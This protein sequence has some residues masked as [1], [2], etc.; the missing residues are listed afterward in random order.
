MK[1]VNKLALVGLVALLGG[2]LSG[3]QKDEPEVKTNPVQEIIN[4]AEKMDEE[5]LYKKAVEEINGKSF[6]VIAN[7]SRMKDAFPAWVKFINEN[8]K[9]KFGL[10][11]DFKADFSTTQPKNNT[12]FNQIK[13]DVTGTNH[14]ISMTLIQDGSQIK[15]KMTKPGYLLNYIPKEWKESGADVAKDGTPLALQSLSKVFAYNSIDTEEGAFNNVFDFTM[16]DDGTPWHTHFMTPASEPVGANM[17]YMLTNPTYT[18]VVK[19]A[20]DN[21]SE[22]QKKIVDA[23]INE[24]KTQKFTALGK[25]DGKDVVSYY[26]NSGIK[27][28]I[29]AAGLSDDPNAKYAL[30]WEFLFLKNYLAE[31]DDGP[32]CTNLTQKS[33]AGESGL[34]VYS[35]FRSITESA[36][37]TLKDMR[38]A[39]YEDGY[40][41][42]GGYMYKH[43]LQI[44]AT[45]PAP[46]TSCAFIHFMTN[47]QEGFKPWGKDAGGYSANPRVQANFDHSKD[48]NGEDGTVE[49]PVK[50]DKGYAWWTAN[51][52][53]KGRLVLEDGE[54]CAKVAAPMSEWISYL[55]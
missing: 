54:Y 52:A 51:E 34:L 48:G 37:V 41:G 28:Q 29:T 10:T 2:A 12:I 31:T 27:D 26:G 24:D 33:A 40:K 11:S 35:K 17:L 43:Y 13:G 6:T 3:C 1:H 15:S 21:A 36:T 30:A 45:S 55:R 7:S 9:E 18:A 42:F 50:N 14:S 44:L 5:E 39:A 4:Q 38:V 19:E 23:V 46:W 32:M 25:D 47:H 16:K 22:T 53:G 8:Y 49:Y 20:Y